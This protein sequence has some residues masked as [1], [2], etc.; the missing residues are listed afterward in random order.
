MKGVPERTPSIP[1]GPN[2]KGVLCV[3]SVHS[4]PWTLWS[5]IRHRFSNSHPVRSPKTS[6]HIRLLSWWWWVKQ[7]TF[8]PHSVLGHLS[9]LRCQVDGNVFIQGVICDVCKVVQVVEAVQ[10]LPLFGPPQ[11]SIPV[12][13]EN[14]GGSERRP[15]PSGQ[16]MEQGSPQG[17]THGGTGHSATP[18]Q[19]LLLLETPPVSCQVLYY[20]FHLRH[21]PLK[22]RRRPRLLMLN[23]VPKVTEWGSGGWDTNIS[24]GQ[25][26][27]LYSGTCN[28]HEDRVHAIRIGSPE[29]ILPHEQ[30]QRAA[31]ENAEMSLRPHAPRVQPRIYVLKAERCSSDCNHTQKLRATPPDRSLQGGANSARSRQCTSKTFTRVTLPQLSAATEETV[32][33]TM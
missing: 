5:F 6:P 32:K 4:F 8:P 29:P 2:S 16:T 3:Y 23:D 10:P 19:M 9:Q 30:R 14:R 11:Q 21:P 17:R 18:C 24:D 1:A 25:V 15:T 12:D 31:L 26:Q 7:H 28:S 13:A 33:L 20:R 27:S 22:Q